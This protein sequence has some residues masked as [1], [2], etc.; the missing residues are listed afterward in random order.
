LELGL[1]LTKPKKMSHTK[2]EIWYLWYLK[3][4]LF[5]FL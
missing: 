2:R 3:D 1:C 5:K 4:G